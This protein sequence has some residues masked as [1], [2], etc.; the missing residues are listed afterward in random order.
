MGQLIKLL[1]I[2]SC[3]LK[4]KRKFCLL[5]KTFGK[6]QWQSHLSPAVFEKLIQDC[7]AELL[8][9]YREAEIKE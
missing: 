7:V 8:I 9:E 5:C 1:K 3:H 2:H 6:H 4:M